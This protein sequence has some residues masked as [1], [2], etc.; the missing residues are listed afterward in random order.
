MMGLN[1]V[2]TDKYKQKKNKEKLTFRQKVTN[3]SKMMCDI[4]IVYLC[5]RSPVF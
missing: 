3:D 1:D 5:E 2:E 4:Y